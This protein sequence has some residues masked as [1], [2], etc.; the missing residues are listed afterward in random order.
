MT[1]QASPETERALKHLIKR[2]TRSRDWSM[3]VMLFHELGLLYQEEE[4]ELPENNRSSGDLAWV[5]LSTR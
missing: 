4:G 1:R 3:L 5:H 2:A